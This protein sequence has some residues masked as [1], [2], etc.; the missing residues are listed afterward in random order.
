[1]FQLLRHFSIASLISIAAASIAL[2][3]LHR[4]MAVDELVRLGESGNVEITRVVANTYREP[5]RELLAAAP[6]LSADALRMHPRTVALHESIRAAVLGT[7]VIKIKLYNLDGRTVYS[8]EA[9]QI[10]EDKRS[11]AGFLAA[12]GGRVATE[13][14]RRDTFSAFEQTLENRSVL[15]SYLPLRTDDSRPV[16]AVFEVYQDI[17]PFLAHVDAAQRKVVAGVLA[18]L[19]LLYAALFLVVRRADRIL[20]QQARQGEADAQALHHLDARRERYLSLSKLSSDWFWDQDREYRFIDLDS[21]QESF[22]GINRSVHFGKTRWELPN[23]EPI[24][25]SWEQHRADL[26]ARRPFRNLLLRRS[27]PGGV[28]Y[29]SVSGE[30][31]FDADGRFDGYRG[32][33]SDVTER[34][35]AE[36]S[37]AQTRE[38]LAQRAEKLAHADFLQALLDALP[39]GVTLLDKNLDV[40]VSNEASATLQEIP[41][42]L[43]AQGAPVRSVFLYHAER[44]VYGPGDVD[45]LADARM[46]GMRNPNPIC[47]ERTLPSGRS[48]EVRSAWLPNGCRVTTFVDITD[49]KRAEIEL[50]AARDAAE[51]GSQAKSNFLAVMSHEI[52]TPMNAVIGLLELLRLSPLDAEQRETVDTVR[53]SGQSL[54]RLIDD[55]LDFSKIE[56]GKLVLHLEPSSLARLFES[57]HHA[58][59]GV[60]SHKGVLLTQRLDARIA[61]ALL[62]DRLRL[63]QIVNNLLSNAIK[64]TERGQVELTAELIEHTE[65]G[66]RVRISVRDTGI[67]IEAQALKGLFVPFSQADAGVQRRYGGTGL[68]LAICQRLAELMGST[69]EVQSAPGVGSRIGLTLML[70]RAEQA[71][72]HESRPQAIEAIARALEGRSTPT[73]DAARAEGRLILVVDDHPVNRRML[74]RQLNVLGYAVKTAA[75]GHEAL[76]HWRG[77][78]FGLVI[79]DCQMPGMD[80]YQLA[81]AIRQ[82]E[83]GSGQRLPIVACTANVSRE[84]LDQCHAVGMDDALTKPLE[85]ATLKQQLDRWLPCEAMLGSDEFDEPPPLDTDF[86]AIAELAQG[87]AALQREL[88]EDFRSANGGDLRAAARAVHDVAIDDV[89]RAAHRIKGAATTVGAARLA[90]AATRLERAAHAGDWHRVSSAWAPLQEECER[91]DRRI[92]VKTCPEAERR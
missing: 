43:N 56:A 32:V 87:D 63:R 14:T 24:G 21:K 34:V 92:A 4:Q 47:A 7:S 29:I 17:T 16:G 15:A 3:M 36:L 76:A 80:G 12:R 25:I 11:N 37:L 48:F 8:S 55:V 88:L 10:G 73:A 62:V 77:G 42:A 86:A 66:D 91:L 79:T 60:A 51:A 57:A 35:Q 39:V 85:L 75:D 27:P 20:V 1:V 71:E 90:E 65:G 45:A 50:V 59:A 6:E 81:R 74:A 28:S 89:R 38:A 33:A 67:G 83:A 61:P 64:F 9:R 26:D 78:G 82:A 23:T 2:S 13:L 30:P 46:A 53:E 68:G 69:I 70:G 44:G 22:G 84:A 5:L 41:P 72:P 49:H 54:L 58:F 19:L 40:L 31:V 52:R 18:V